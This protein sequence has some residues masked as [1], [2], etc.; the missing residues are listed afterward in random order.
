MI[1]AQ[2]IIKEN[3]DIKRQRDKQKLI[4]KEQDSKMIEEIKR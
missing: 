2:K 3:E 1:E 4:E